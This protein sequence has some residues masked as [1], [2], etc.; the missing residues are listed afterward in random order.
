[1]FTLLCKRRQTTLKIREIRNERAIGGDLSG[2][3]MQG[4]VTTEPDFDRL[5][6]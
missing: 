4:R 6:Q 1:M 2:F 5:R 3:E